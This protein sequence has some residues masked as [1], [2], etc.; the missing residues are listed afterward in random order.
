MED[1]VEPVIYLGLDEGAG[2]DDLDIVGLMH[3][4][5]LDVSLPPPPPSG[6]QTPESREAIIC[7]SN[8][9]QQSFLNN[10]LNYENYSRK[11]KHA[12]KSC[13]RFRMNT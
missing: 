6:Q 7:F 4:Q 2:V 8:F 3:H 5:S 11:M 13:P 1:K 9:V 10:L 12:S